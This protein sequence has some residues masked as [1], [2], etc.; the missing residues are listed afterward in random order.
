VI[1]GGGVSR[2]RFPLIGLEDVVGGALAVVAP[3]LGA[4]G[5]V[6][7]PFPRAGRVGGVVVGGGPLVHA[8]RSHVTHQGG[9]WGTG[10]SDQ[11]TSK[12]TLLVF[13]SSSR[14][15]LEV[16]IMGFIFC[17]VFLISTASVG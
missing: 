12:Y 9:L 10:Q 8:G 14:A 7:G 16:F 15:L 2:R 6:I 17:S 5:R 1:N 13:I 3:P 11:P 4:F